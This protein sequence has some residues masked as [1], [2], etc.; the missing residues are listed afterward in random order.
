M[1]DVNSTEYGIQSAP[2]IS[3][4]LDPTKDKGR[5]RIA[6]FS[7]SA[8][9]PGATDRLLH[10]I[11]PAGKI[12]ILR[13]VG[14]RQ[15]FSAG[16]T[17]SIGHLG[18]TTPAG[19]ATAASATAFLAAFAMDAAT[20]LDTLVDITIDSRS[21][22]TVYGQLAVAGAAAKNLIGWLEYVAD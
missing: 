2:P 22:F 17:M 12:R 4:P 11:M 5:I 13:Y 14:K 6:S 15:A 1:A 10:C 18:Y 3:S 7:F 20:D 21:G 9:S 8:I 16:S 19:V